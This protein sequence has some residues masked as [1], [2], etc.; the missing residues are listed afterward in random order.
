MSAPR[1]TPDVGWSQRSQ[2]HQHPLLRRGGR[3]EFRR[4]YGRHDELGSGTPARFER[5]RTAIH[6]TDIT[7]PAPANSRDHT[8]R[9]A[10]TSCAPGTVTLFSEPRAHY[11]TNVVTHATRLIGGRGART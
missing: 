10:R 4:A 6:A 9:A 11:T 2:S 3:D 1:A 8:L 5:V 7:V